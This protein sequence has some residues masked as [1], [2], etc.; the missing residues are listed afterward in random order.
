MSGASGIFFDISE[1]SPDVQALL[2]LNPIAVL[3]TEYRQVLLYGAWP[4]WQSLAIITG[5]GV[6]LSAFGLYLIERFD[7]TFPKVIL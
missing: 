1:R 5:V 4:D 2:Y 7:R 6:A 3:I